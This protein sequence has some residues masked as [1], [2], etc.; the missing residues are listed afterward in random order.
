M[1]LTFSQS[2]SDAALAP[3]TYISAAGTRGSILR[4][5]IQSDSDTGISAGESFSTIVSVDGNPSS[6]LKTSET[7]NDEGDI[8][9]IVTPTVASDSAHVTVIR[10]KTG[11]T[12]TFPALTKIYR[13]AVLVGPDDSAIKTNSISA[14]SLHIIDND[15]QALTGAKVRWTSSKPIFHSANKTTY[16]TYSGESTVLNPSGLTPGSLQIQ[17]NVEALEPFTLN[18]DTETDAE[19]PLPAPQLK[20]PNGNITII[21]DDLILALSG[22]ALPF[23]ITGPVVGWTKDFQIILFMVKL[24]STDGPKLIFPYNFEQKI[25]APL[26]PIKS[27]VSTD[28]F[29]FTDKIRVFY[30]VYDAVLNPRTSDDLLINVKRKDFPPVVIQSSLPA[31]VV[32]P[33]EYNQANLN[34]NDPMVVKINLRASDQWAVGDTIQVN[35]ALTGVS[36]P[37]AGTIYP[38]PQPTLYTVLATDI[39]ATVTINLPSTTFTGVDD[40]RGTV[41]YTATRAAVPADPTISSAA[42]IRVDV[43]PP[44]GN[45]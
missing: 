30:T 38:I 35:I 17:A 36:G 45:S 32:T 16:T 40:S 24:S 44:L 6:L 3:I 31:P 9:L 34:A 1:S 15:G 13:S 4:I 7:Y 28:L 37:D 26:F 25:N 8:D 27:P 18:L 14:A 43:I 22:S 21:D 41:T 19:I 20:L 39:G 42:P 23:Y 33:Q 2:G 11:E 12:G 5:R 10:R 29:N